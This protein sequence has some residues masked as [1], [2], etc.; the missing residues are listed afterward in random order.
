MV[1]RGRE[2]NSWN[3]TTERNEEEDKKNK[4]TK[5]NTGKGEGATHGG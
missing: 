1:K 3:A 5:K 4:S 2:K